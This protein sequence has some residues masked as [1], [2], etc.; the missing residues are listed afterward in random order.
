MYEDDSNVEYKKLFNVPITCY[1]Q[2]EAKEMGLIEGN[3]NAIW[4]IVVFVVV[5]GFFVVRR[6]RK[7]RRIE[8]E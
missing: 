4:G 2:K 1:T 6:I 7:K 5:V 3:N 8:E